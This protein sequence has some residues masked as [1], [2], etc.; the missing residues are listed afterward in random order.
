MN[1]V[2]KRGF[3]VYRIFLKNKLAMSAMM[4]V[5]GVM[6]LI[7]AVNGRGND[8]VSM[9]LGITA[10]G[11]IFTF[12]SFYKLGYLRACF[13]KAENETDKQIGRA[14]VV[15]QVC[16][17]LVYLVVA[18]I[19]V[20][21]LINHG[22]MNTVLNLM[23]GFFTTLNG[24][25]GAMMLI[26]NRQIRG[27]RWWIKIVLT[28]IELVIGP[29]FIVYAVDID[30]GWFTAMAVLTTVAGVIEVV[31]ALT[32]ESIRNTKKDGEDIMKIIKDEKPGNGGATNGS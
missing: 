2:V 13:E 23:A 30:Q 27:W 3:G 21:L 32:W 24:V 1:T 9:P 22:L 4:L 29:H 28:V 7:A 10:A 5:S 18:V 25:T 8:T 20:F 15:L 6:M 16:E 31:S 17:T 26:K 12:W 19:G 14:N 11:A